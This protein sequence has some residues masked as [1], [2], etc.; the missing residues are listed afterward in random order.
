MV[1]KFGHLGGGRFAA[2]RARE[3]VYI[4][5]GHTSGLGVVQIRAYIAIDISVAS[6]PSRNHIGEPS[7]DHALESRH[8]CGRIEIKAILSICGGVISH[9]ALD[10]GW[11][12]AISAV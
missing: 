2:F 4:S 6:V 5:L 7:V 1:D 9:T 12:S 10:I 3:N 11:T 8:R